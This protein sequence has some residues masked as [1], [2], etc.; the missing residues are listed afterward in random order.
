M[1]AA[2]IIAASIM[3]VYGMAENG[4]ASGLVWSMELV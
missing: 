2:L 3:T 4:R 1:F